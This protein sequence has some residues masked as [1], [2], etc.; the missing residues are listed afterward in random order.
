VVTRRGFQTLAELNPQVGKELRVLAASPDLIAT[1]FC[2]RA[3]FKSSEM[4]RIVDALRNFH[5]T[6]AG[7]QVL[8]VFQSDRLQEIP[9][10]ALASARR[11]YDSDRATPA[12]QSRKA[13]N[14]PALADHDGR[15][16]P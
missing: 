3:E 16:T 6:A 9:A 7:R 12:R 1:V 13:A 11:L 8:T 10:T 14:A 2:F 4:D 5:L 15:G